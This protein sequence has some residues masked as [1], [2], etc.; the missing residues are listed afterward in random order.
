[1]GA[2]HDEDE[3]GEGYE[4]YKYGQSHPELRPFHLFFAW[5]VLVI[6][7]CTRLPH[8]RQP[9]SALLQVPD[10]NM[11]AKSAMIQGARMIV[12]S[13]DRLE[14]AVIVPARPGWCCLP[15]SRTS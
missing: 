12:C 5:H 3:N 15:C 1:G 2:G 9:P 6:A 11:P 4:G 10:H 7:P 8:R 14:L 13:G